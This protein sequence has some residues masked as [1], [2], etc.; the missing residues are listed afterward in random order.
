[1][2][3][4][5]GRS[6]RDDTLCISL[7]LLADPIFGFLFSVSRGARSLKDSK[8]WK[9]MALALGLILLFMTGSVFTLLS[10]FYDYMAIWGWGG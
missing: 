5:S 4:G 6:S 7:S 8:F 3:L 1:M 9:R 2:V 10:Q